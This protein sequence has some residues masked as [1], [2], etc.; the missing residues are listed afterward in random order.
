[1][2]AKKAPSFD[3]PKPIVDCAFE[4]CRTPAILRERHIGGW[5]NLCE[6][7]WLKSH[8]QRSEENCKERGLHTLAE[9]KAFC[10]QLLRTVIPPEREPGSDD[11]FI[12]HRHYLVG[13]RD[14]KLES[15]GG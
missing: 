2:A 3:L 10:R 1:M 9:R 15:A 11:D 6:F 4:G 8:S 12:Q 14:K 7:H 5:A 13:V